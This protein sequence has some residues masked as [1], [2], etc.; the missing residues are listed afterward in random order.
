MRLYPGRMLRRNT[1]HLG[2]MPL[3]PRRGFTLI[4][5]LVV[6]AI[7]AILAA[8]LLPALSKGKEK[9]RVVR[10]LNNMHQLSVGWVMYAVDNNDWLV[11]NWVPGGNPPPSTWAT[12]N[13]RSTPTN[14]S[15]IT[16]GLLYPYHPS[17]GIYQCPDTVP[18]NGAVQVRTVSM[19]VR[20]G[21]ADTAD[22][23]Q[24]GV[25]DSCSSDLGAAYPMFKKMP[26]VCQPAP[27]AA[28]LFAD[29]SLNSVDDCIFG[30]G[31]TSFRNSPTAHHSNGATFSFADGHVQRWGWKGIRSEQGIFAPANGAALLD[32]QRMLN[33]VALP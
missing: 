23:N 13:R 12:G 31:W 19:I 17:L 33:G 27:A 16:T 15:D 21:G 4:E 14:T 30:M 28:L 29:E 32:L 24:Y 25:W 5:L 2:N 22:A 9:A 6:I 7:I 1:S 8:L 18:L 3:P 11:R 26:Q 20:M 10:C